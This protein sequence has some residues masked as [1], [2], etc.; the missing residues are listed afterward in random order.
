MAT[1]QQS[2]ILAKLPEPRPSDPPFR[3]EV[4]TYLRREERGVAWLA[5]Q[6]FVTRQCLHQALNGKDPISANL[7]ESVAKFIGVPVEQLRD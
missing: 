1:A 7:R 6:V 2:P 5:R 3:R 4:L